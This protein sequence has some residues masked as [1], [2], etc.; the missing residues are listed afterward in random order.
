MMSS[1]SGL[2]GEED[3]LDKESCLFSELTFPVEGSNE[4]NPLPS[5]KKSLPLLIS[6]VYPVFATLQTVQ[7]YFLIGLH[8]AFWLATD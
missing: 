4:A 5:W 3:C 2:F 6:F 1:Q 7:N 8:F